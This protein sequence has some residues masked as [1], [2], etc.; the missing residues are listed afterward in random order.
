MTN[1]R[2]SNLKNI[3]L[4]ICILFFV[5]NTLG[6]S[7]EKSF[8]HFDQ[9]IESLMHD[10]K[11][12]GLSVAVIQNNKVIYSKGFGYRDLEKKLPVTTKTVFPIGSVTKAFTGALLGILEKENK[13]DL[14]AKPS[15]YIPEFK[16]YNDKMNDRITIEDLLS[17]K[18]GIGNTGTADVF[19]PTK[20]RLKAVKR[21]QY[22]K[23]EAAIKNSFAYS[24]MGYTLAGTIAEQV[25]HKTWDNSIKEE[26]F[27]PLAMQNSY[28]TLAEMVKSAE[29]SLPYGLYQGEVEEVQ[30]EKFHSLSPA[31]A[32]K[33]NVIDM[34]NWIMTWLNKGRFEEKQI[35]PADYVEKASR[36][37]N[38]NN[39]TYE[40]DAFLFGEG[41]GWRLRS[42]SL[43][44]I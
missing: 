44:H 35:I 6:Q 33:S 8:H 4:L 43:I 37:Q 23:P 26:I 12:V 5:H 27:G 11:A 28:T 32:I 18:S 10:Y 7:N 21:L 2:D 22:L 13:V 19:F 31:G 29:Y 42:L 1:I 40:Q 25:T 14:K 15:A 20:N 39:Y 3:F 24:N 36:L 16:F 41:F 17:H 9:K 30:Y 34:T 38:I